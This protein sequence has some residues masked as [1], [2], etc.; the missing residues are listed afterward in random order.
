MPVAL[1]QKQEDSSPQ[2]FK[3]AP[4]Y[5]DFW[6]GTLHE[7]EQQ[8]IVSL[9]SE[10]S[11][12]VLH[13]IQH[14]R[15]FLVANAVNK[16]EFM[17][18]V[19]VCEA[20]IDSL[21]H[22]LE[23]TDSRPVCI[24]LLRVLNS[25]TIDCPSFVD[26][27]ILERQQLVK[28][29][30]AVL[31][32][33]TDV[34]QREILLLFLRNLFGADELGSC[35]RAVDSPGAVLCEQIFVP[36]L[37][38]ALFRLLEA[39]TSKLSRLCMLKLLSFVATL[40]SIAQTCLECHALQLLHRLY[41]P[42]HSGHLDRSVLKY[43][44]K[45]VLFVIHS[46]PSA[47]A[48]LNDII[49]S[50]TGRLSL[51]ILASCSG[52]LGSREN[53]EDLAACSHLLNDDEEMRAICGLLRGVICWRF[54][55][56]HRHPYPRPTLNKRHLRTLLHRPNRGRRALKSVSGED[57]VADTED[58]SSCLPVEQCDTDQF[59]L[60]LPS[61]DVIAFHVIQPLTESCLSPNCSTKIVAWACSTLVLLFSKRPELH[62][63]TL[64]A[65]AFVREIDLA[66]CSK[67]KGISQSVN[68]SDNRELMDHLV[69]LLKL[70]TFL[71]AQNESN[72]LK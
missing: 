61:E 66:V 5:D 72:R 8:V 1:S 31:L 30:F 59:S 45:L 23:A 40:P 44:F 35:F 60:V 3:A 55:D 56:G 65:N 37:V 4:S 38:S 36:S 39:E 26:H 17:K 64:Y 2:F 25:L 71:A 14:L 54:L 24:A 27:F 20:L 49:I 41:S 7:L 10:N 58:S 15:H 13:G 29:L 11:S 70:F 67:L 32:Q 22:W 42:D 57:D 34:A 47:L 53:E 48:T 68:R 51:V 46:C 21:R 16:T 63:W 28:Q 19:G 12:T 50:C 6:L 52:F 9:A 18:N 62:R 69:P 43:A 33:S